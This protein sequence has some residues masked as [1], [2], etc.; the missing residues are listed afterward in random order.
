MLNVALVSQVDFYWR[1]VPVSFST[2]RILWH[3]ASGWSWHSSVVRV[4]WQ[5]SSRQWLLDVEELQRYSPEQFVSLDHLDWDERQQRVLGERRVMIGSLVVDA[6]PMQAISDSDRA[7][8]LAAGIRQ[9]GA[10]CLPWTDNCR[11]WQAR[12]L[13]MRTLSMQGK[14]AEFPQVDDETLIDQLD[15]W[16]L[17]WLQGMGSMKALRQLD[18]LK[19]LSAMLDYQQQVLMDDWLPM[20]YTVPSGSQIRLDY[21]QPGNP[22]LSV[23]LQE[24]LG[25]AENPTIA[26]GQIPLKVELLSPA[27]RPVQVTEDLANFWT[28]S[29][30]AVKKDMAGRYPKH[31]WPDDPL[32]AQPTSRAKPRK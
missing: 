4:R 6:R 18:L 15:N 10:S 5:E 2:G 12:V 1:V 23:R 13:R 17:P 30:P 32:A 31:V 7:M 9:R 24:M 8:A 19:A 22:V 27:R 3:I 16:L 20:R 26:R 21:S 29:Y 14:V 11:E 28:S 25:C